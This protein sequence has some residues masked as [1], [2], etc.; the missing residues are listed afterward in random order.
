MG[1]FIEVLMVV[2][3]IVVVLGAPALVFLRV[4]A[5]RKAVPKEDVSR[6]IIELSAENANDLSKKLA[7]AFSDARDTRSEQTFDFFQLDPDRI[8]R[9]RVGPGK[10]FKK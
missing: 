7:E 1:A 10:R 4:S 9:F 2:L 8:L 6:T 3:F 5:S